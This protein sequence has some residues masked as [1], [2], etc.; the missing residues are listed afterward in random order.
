MHLRLL[1]LLLLICVPTYAELVLSELPKD[2][3]HWRTS[4]A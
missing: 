1:S 4:G 2:L 3:N